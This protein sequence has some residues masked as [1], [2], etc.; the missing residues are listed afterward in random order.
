MTKRWTYRRI[1]QCLSSYVEQGYLGVPQS[2]AIGGSGW[3]ADPDLKKRLQANA[4]VTKFVGGHSIK[5]G[6]PWNRSSSLRED[7]YTG[8]F[9]RQI[10]PTS[11]YFRDRWR[12][13]QGESFTDLFGVFLQDSWKVFDRLTVNFGVRLEGEWRFGT[14]KGATTTPA[15]LRAAGVSGAG[16]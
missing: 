12:V 3:Y 7:K 11:N 4:D 6:I 2:Y 1:R 10:R 14:A 13:T 16:P 15:R 9:Y 5:A 8:G